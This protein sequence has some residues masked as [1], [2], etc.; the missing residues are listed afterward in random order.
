MTLEVR[1]LVL[2]STISAGDDID[3]EGGGKPNNGPPCSGAA[4]DYE[5]RERLKTEILAECQTLLL[6]QLQQLRER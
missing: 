3:G 6:A 5:S 4:N 2:K 1:Q